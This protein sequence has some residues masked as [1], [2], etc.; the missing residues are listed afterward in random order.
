MELS[1]TLVAHSLPSLTTSEPA[2]LATSPTLFPPPSP[3]PDPAMLSAE[4]L[5][6]TPSTAFPQSLIFTSNR[7]DPRESGDTIEVFETL[8]SVSSTTFNHVN[9]IPTKLHHLRGMVFFGPDE[10]FLIAGGANGGGIKVFKRTESSVLEEVAWLE[11][12][13]LNPTGFLV[14]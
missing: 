3:T 14:L 7:N 10:K 8:P 12:E 11:T 13:G 9:S 2:V 1:N 6:P 5:I 4:L